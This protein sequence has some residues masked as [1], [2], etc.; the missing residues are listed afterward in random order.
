M[1]YHK[2]CCRGFSLVEI[3]VSI[4]ILIIAI[5]GTFTVFTSTTRLRHF[6][7]NELEARYL[8]QSWLEHV[9]T[10]CSP[11]TRYRS[12]NTVSGKDLNAVDSI[13]RENYSNWPM[14]KKSVISVND[15]SYTVA[16]I[17]IG[18]DE[19]PFKKIT[20]EVEWEMN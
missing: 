10:G 18:S 4:I 19:Y 11:A 20:V 3:L 14:A 2:N 5:V 17:S 9:R 12:I 7:E 13:L 8:A 15:V 6:S 1:I 16:E